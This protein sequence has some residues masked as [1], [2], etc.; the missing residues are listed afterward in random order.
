MANGNF[1]RWPTG[2]TARLN[3]SRHCC[4]SST[5][6]FWDLG[7]KHFD[8]DTDT[9][10][11][12]A[13]CSGAFRYSF[14]RR[15]SSTRLPSL[16]NSSKTRW[17]AA[18]ETDESHLKSKTPTRFFSRR[19]IPARTHPTKYT[20]LKKVMVLLVIPSHASRHISQIRCRSFSPFCFSACVGSCSPPSHNAPIFAT[21]EGSSSLRRSITNFLRLSSQSWGSRDILNVC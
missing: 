1:E 15:R 21:N 5:G 14:T 18:T 4:R 17:L 2:S 9:N 19:V 13:N 8:C 7:Q 11:S 6:I 10:G 12:H 16:S 20:C 3:W